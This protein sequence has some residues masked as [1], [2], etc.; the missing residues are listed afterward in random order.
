MPDP[1]ERL[2]QRAHKAARDR[3]DRLVQPALRDQPVPSVMLGRLV[4]VGRRVRPVILVRRE[5]P[6][7]RVLPGRPGR[8]GRPGHRERQVRLVRLV[9]PA[10]R[11]RLARAE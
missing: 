5:R 10:L 4:L 8:P 9:Q 11:D 1:P 7:R 2:V 3:L 6:G